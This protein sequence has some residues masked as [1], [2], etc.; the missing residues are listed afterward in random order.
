MPSNNNMQNTTYF[1][2]ILDLSAF[3][4]AIAIKIGR[5]TAKKN[6]VENKLFLVLFT[7]R[8]LLLNSVV[9]LVNTL[10]NSNRYSQM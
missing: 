2:I 5:L 4:K 10:A 1:D 6:V 9:G 7:F 8:K 3:A